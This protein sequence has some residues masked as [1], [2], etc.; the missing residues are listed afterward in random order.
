MTE[1]VQIG[2][3]RNMIKTG[4]FLMQNIVKKSSKFDQK[5]VRFLFQTF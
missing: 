5:C 3:L 2:V 1:N 4:I